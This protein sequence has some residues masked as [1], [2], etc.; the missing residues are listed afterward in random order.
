MGSPVSV[1]NCMMWQ[2]PWRR[3][4][5]LTTAH[6]SRRW[7]MPKTPSKLCMLGR[8]RLLLARLTDS[9]ALMIFGRENYGLTSLDVRGPGSILL[10]NQS[11]Q[12]LDPV[13]SA[14]P[15][16]DGQTLLVTSLDGHIRLMD[17]S[18]GKMLNDFTG[19][20]NN[21]YRCRACF[22]RAEDSVVCGDE[23]GMVWAWDLLAVGL[24]LP[25]LHIFLILRRLNPLTPIL[26]RKLI[27]KWSPGQSTIH[28]TQMKWLLLAPMAQLKFGET[29]LRTRHDVSIQSLDL[30]DALSNL[31]LWVS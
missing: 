19:H 1:M 18:T 23:K 5:E 27:Q 29:L 13:T 17:M 16:Q 3:I 15:T 2:D 6:R 12:I 11:W 21:S 26:L 22:G 9:S 10:Y 24:H 20:T 31:I 7:K 4:P 30:S 8:P 25:L 14:V 28:L